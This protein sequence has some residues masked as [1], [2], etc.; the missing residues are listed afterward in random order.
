M[1][2]AAA[3]L[4]ALLGLAVAVLGIAAAVNVISLR[5]LLAAAEAHGAFVPHLGLHALIGDHRTVNSLELACG[6][7]GLGLA[8]GAAWCLRGRDWRRQRLTR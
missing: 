2:M 3:L 8:A 5:A 7:G 4:M 6:V 1:V